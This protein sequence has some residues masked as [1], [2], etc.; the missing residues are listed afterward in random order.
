[1]RYVCQILA[2]QHQHL[3]QQPPQLKLS[4]KGV[5]PPLASSLRNSLRVMCVRSL[6]TSASACTHQCGSRTKSY[7]FSAGPWLCVFYVLQAMSMLPC[8]N[9]TDILSS[10]LKCYHAIQVALQNRV[11]IG[12]AIL[13]MTGSCSQQQ[14]CQHQDKCSDCQ[15]DS[16]SVKT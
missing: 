8:V 3:R 14:L 7:E 9:H 11:K 1:M 12:L 6:L 13:F 2:H 4:S 10:T 16:S 5:R 15:H